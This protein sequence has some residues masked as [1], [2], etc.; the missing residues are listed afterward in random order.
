M[1]LRRAAIVAPLRTPVGKF[2]GALAN[3]SA[4]ELGATVLKA[5]IDRTGIDASRV[6][7]V[8]FAQGYARRKPC[9]RRRTIGADARGSRRM[10]SDLNTQVQEQRRFNGELGKARHDQ[11]V[12]DRV[13]V[14]RE[15]ARQMRAYREGR[16]VIFNSNLKS[17]GIGRG[18]RG[19][20][21][22]A[23]DKIVSLRMEDGRTQKFQPGRLPP[24]L[25]RDA[26]SVF[27]EKQIV[28][29]EGDRIR[30]TANEHDRALANNDIARVE[31]IGKGGITIST[32][33][34]EVLDLKHGDPM[35]ERLD[36][37]YSVNAHI[38][39][40]MT[41]KDG[42]MVLS[43][44]ERTLNSARSFLVV[45][46][47][48]TGEATLIVDNAKGLER[49]VTLNSG[50]KTSAMEIAG[51]RPGKLDQAMAGTVLAVGAVLGI[52]RENPE[53]E[54]ERSR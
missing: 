2:G 48:F 34:G 42:I 39:Q 9:L 32:R 20:V 37:A 12:L 41:A 28:L 4:A 6:D 35:L 10:R 16:I 49:D 8:V 52:Q 54:I 47:R 26:V 38:A 22:G 17:Q 29:Y 27:A 3:V 24:N 1:I 40:G 14:T 44:R 18:E 43:E 31:D 33:D 45:A 51:G 46:S 11:L 23:D 50:D 36:L 13:T 25:D 15:G 5:V 30:W 21:I 53:R 19:S 7:D